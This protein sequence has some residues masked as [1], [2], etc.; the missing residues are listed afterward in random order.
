MTASILSGAKNARLTQ[1]MVYGEQIATNV[2]TNNNDNQL[3]GVFRI[4]ATPRPDHT[5]PELQRAIDRE[6]KRLADL[7]PTDRELLQANNVI[8]SNMLG[9]VETIQGKANYLNEYYAETGNP[10]AFQRYL[11]QMRSVTAADVQRVVRQ[12]LLGPRAI[13]TVVPAGKSDLAAVPRRAT[14]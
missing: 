6:L 2:Y 12:Y 3:A 1:S 14:P 8:E 10:D 4:V 13:I 5:V 7:G 11:D 9:A